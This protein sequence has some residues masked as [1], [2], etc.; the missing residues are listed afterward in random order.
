EVLVVVPVPFGRVD[1]VADEYDVGVLDRDLGLCLQGRCNQ[2]LAEVESLVAAAFADG[3][4]DLLGIFQRGR[5]RG[6]LLEPRTAVAGLQAERLELFHNPSG[7]ALGTGGAG[8]A[9]AHGVGGN[10]LV[11]SAEPLRGDRGR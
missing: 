10:A 3:E 7:G 9:S 4:L 5:N 1:A 8:F 11:V 6:H 2:V